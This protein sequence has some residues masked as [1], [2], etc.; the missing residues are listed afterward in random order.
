MNKQV[1]RS[2]DTDR[3]P[4]EKLTALLETFGLKH[5]A[6]DLPAIL[7]RAENSESTNRELLL[8][9][10]ETEVKG[11]NTRRRKR[12]YAAAHLPPDPKP[13]EMFDP[14]ELDSGI[15]ESQLRQLKELNWIDTKANIILAGPPG[16][17][18]DHD[19]YRTGP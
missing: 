19:R 14:S 9:L 3:I 10:L 16:L 4:I 12:N 1:I 7:E 13:I 6:K 11:R 5:S 15:T 2:L 18:K 8:D 17:G